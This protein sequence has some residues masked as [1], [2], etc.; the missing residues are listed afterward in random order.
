LFILREQLYWYNQEGFCTYTPL[1]ICD[2]KLIANLEPVEW[3]KKSTFY[4]IFP[5]TFFRS[6]QTIGVSDNELL[7][8]NIFPSRALPWGGHPSYWGNSGYMDFF[9]GDLAGI[10]EKIPY[11]L[12]LGIK[13]LYLT[14]IFTSPTQHRYSIVDFMNVDSHL[15]GND[16]LVSLVEALH[17]KGIRIILDLTLNHCSKQ[18]PWFNEAVRNRNST[19]AGFFTF[20]NQGG[21]RGWL[22]DPNLPEFNYTSNVLREIMVSNPDSVIRH[23]LL[24]PY[25]V[26]GWRLD[27]SNRIGRTGAFQLSRSV[28]K[29]IRNSVKS[30]SSDKYIM[31]ENFFDSSQQLQGDE[32]DAVQNETGL[33]I[34]IL[35]WVAPY[36]LPAGP[37][38]TKTN[39][40]L[41]ITTQEFA[42][43]LTEFQKTIPWVIF[44]QQ[45]NQLTN[46]DSPRLMTL[47]ESKIP[48]VK[49]ALGLLFSLP[50]TPCF[51]YGDE[52]GMLGANALESRTC[53]RWD[54]KDWN[55]EL[56]NYI[57]T[58]ARIRWER[59]SIT[60]GGFQI[61]YVGDDVFAFSRESYDE[62]L[63][64]L[65]NRKPIEK[66]ALPMDVLGIQDGENLVDILSDEEYVLNYG[67][68]VVEN[69]YEPGIRFLVKSNKDRVL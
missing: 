33:G 35:M 38:K 21:Y 56:R 23:W 12:D 47:L 54:A 61:L 66:V 48:V 44:A 31:G 29:E 7:G 5:D 52:I 42:S 28:G 1:D 43:Q 26:D 46:H 37:F 69:L 2:F 25:N 14:P 11:F 68:I 55:F 36:E 16:A 67:E 41:Q 22:G 65:A 17:D 24:P 19:E 34:P 60:N 20:D 49:L 58:L 9:N 3:V 64:I 4:Q 53:M 62:V 8:N 15:G 63:V 32:L 6:G 40:K 50:G 51:F 39:L 57:K 45:F 18:H 13:A 27:A 10:K 59:P 30:I